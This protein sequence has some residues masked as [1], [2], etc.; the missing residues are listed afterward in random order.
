MPRV[1]VVIPVF[2]GAG[3]VS[4]AIG[5]ALDQTYDDE[6]EIVVINDGSTDTTAEVL[7]DYS[8][9]I[10]ILDQQNR[11]PRLRATPRWRRQAPSILPSST[12]TMPL[13]RISWRAPCRAWHAIR[14]PR[15]SSM[16]RS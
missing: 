5:S 14:T 7:Q 15:Y 9:R 2:N 16:M 6:L 12:L 8:G 1:A 10:R 3:T 4:R 13:R 11:G